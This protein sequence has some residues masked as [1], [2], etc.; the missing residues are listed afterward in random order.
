MDTLTKLLPL[1]TEEPS[2]T[3]PAHICGCTDSDTQHRTLVTHADTLVES[4]GHTLG[5]LCRWKHSPKGTS[6][7]APDVTAAYSG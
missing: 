2:G 5:L 3:L 6:S 4:R 1:D 7:S